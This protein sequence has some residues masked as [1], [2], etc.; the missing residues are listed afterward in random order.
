MH[1]MSELL[2]RI[3]ADIDKDPYYK[4]NFANDGE[5]FLA[6]YLR[7]I[8]QRTAV[9]A[10][11]DI[12]D[13]QHDKEIDAVIVDDEKRKVFI[14]QGKFFTATAV[15]GGPIQEILT[16]W[17][18]IQ[19]IPSLQEAANEKLR[20]KLEA[21]AEALKDDYEVVFELVTTGT[22][23]DAARKDLE[24]FQNQIVDFAPRMQYHS[25][26][27]GHHQIAVGRGAHPRTTQAETHVQ[28]SGGTLLGRGGWR[29]ENGARCCS[30]L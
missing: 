21:V 6:W 10:R 13:G 24:T 30:A 20:P 14:F 27:F 9:E 4:D 29:S 1:L 16:A 23:T 8:H 22:L 19:D 26:G 25:R 5:R 3:Q 2:T 17:L 11:Q 7:N 18:R 12:T 28:P 15:D